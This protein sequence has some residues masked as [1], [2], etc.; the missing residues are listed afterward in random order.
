MYPIILERDTPIIN[1]AT[2]HLWANALSDPLTGSFAA[3]RS[4][5]LLAG[6]FATMTV[7]EKTAAVTGELAVCAG[8]HLAGPEP[9]VEFT[10]YAISCAAMAVDP[11]LRPFLFVGESP[12]SITN[13]ANGDV[14]TD[15]QL[16]AFGEGPNEFHGSSLAVDMTVVIS[17]KTTDRAVCF[18]I[19]M[20]A[21]ISTSGNKGGYAR[22]SV[23]R[24]IK[25]GP[26][27]IDNR[28]L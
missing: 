24:M 28:K 7:N 26:R 12:A 27:I 21:G 5:G 6:D 4:N 14:V 16:L 11:E 18:G 15:I 1:W 13:G 17:E 25:A 3:V 2:V 23:N 9:G 8:I 10:P 20:M 19:G 22:L